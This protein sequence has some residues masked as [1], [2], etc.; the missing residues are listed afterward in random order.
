MNTVLPKIFSDSDV[1]NKKNPFHPSKQFLLASPVGKMDQAT[2]TDF[3]K[4]LQHL[5]EN[6]DYLKYKFTQSDANTGDLLE[7]KFNILGDL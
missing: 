1:E 2:W 5:S 3:K 4:D 6:C 7:S